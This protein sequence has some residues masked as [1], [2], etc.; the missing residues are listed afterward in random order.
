MI[1]KLIYI[2]STLT[3]ATSAFLLSDFVLEPDRYSET[4][5]QKLHRKDYYIRFN[6]G[7]AEVSKS[8]YRSISIGD[9]VNVSIG[10]NSD[11]VL[12]VHIFNNEGTIT[13]KV[14]S[15]SIWMT[16]LL[17]VIS[18]VAA[19]GFLPIR[20]LSI[21]FK[22]TEKQTKN[23]QAIFYPIVYFVSLAIAYKLIM[24]HLGYI[25]KF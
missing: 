12:E 17:F 22:S 8:E 1:E 4:I 16:G 13:N 3:I 5:T 6:S 11:T 20:T 23:T 24:V 14:S 25:D 15:A 19:S 18:L 10:K 21:I 9:S 7:S 2:F